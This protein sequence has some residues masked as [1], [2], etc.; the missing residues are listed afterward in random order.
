[1]LAKCC[2]TKNNEYVMQ[3]GTQVHLE[4]K[5]SFIGLIFCKKDFDRHLFLVMC[6]CFGLLDFSLI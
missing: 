2:V 3:W 6:L 1:M 4:V 5:T